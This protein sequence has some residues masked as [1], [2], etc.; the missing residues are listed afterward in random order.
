MKTNEWENNVRIRSL[1]DEPR[2]FLF[3]HIRS[4][5]EFG[6]GKDVPLAIPIE[7]IDVRHRSIWAFSLHTINSAPL[8]TIQPLR[9]SISFPMSKRRLDSTSRN[10]VRPIRWS[11]DTVVTRT[12]RSVLTDIQ[13][14]MIICSAKTSDDYYK[15]LNDY[16]NVPTCNACSDKI[17]S[18]EN[19][20]FLVQMANTKLQLVPQAYFRNARIWERWKTIRFVFR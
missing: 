13:P 5:N 20:F 10:N 18:L 19:L 4:R 7:S 15:A 1:S 12:P 6:S 17:D 14:S 11:R 2:R 16:L 8:S 9:S 3:D